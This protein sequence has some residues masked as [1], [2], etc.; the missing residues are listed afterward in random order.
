MRIRNS[1]PMFRGLD[2]NTF[3]LEA[4]VNS[5]TYGGIVSKTLFMFTILVAMVILVSLNAMWFYNNSWLMMASIFGGLIMVII[6]RVNPGTASLTG[7]LYAVFEGVLLGY[8]VAIYS[9]L[10]P[11]V[12][13][14]AVL[15]TLSIFLVMLLLYVT[16]LVRVG[17]LFRRAVTGALVGLFFFV[18]VAWLLSMFSSSFAS[19]FYGNTSLILLISLIAAGIASLMILIDLDNC[20]KLVQ[21]G[22]DKKYEWIASL[23]LMVTIVWLFIEILRIIVILT[24][25]RD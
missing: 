14:A 22:A 3:G 16:G 12:V 10:M 25:R 8:I 5:A 13:E 15:V 24:G 2:K 11:G 19:S 7:P 23:G 9:A 18:M 21:N 4:N 17:P 1:N 20:T 6:A